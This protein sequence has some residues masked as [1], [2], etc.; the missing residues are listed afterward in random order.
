MWPCIGLIAFVV[1]TSLGIG[2]WAIRSRNKENGE[3]HG[4][5]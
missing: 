1:L 2:W 3:G 4:S 5:N